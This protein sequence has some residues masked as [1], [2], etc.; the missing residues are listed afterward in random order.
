MCKLVANEGEVHNVGE[1]GVGVGVCVQVKQIE[2]GGH[3]HPE[4]VLAFVPAV[5]QKVEG[6]VVLEQGCVP[7]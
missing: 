4:H 5:L 1:G 6:K 2:K 7:N 3:K